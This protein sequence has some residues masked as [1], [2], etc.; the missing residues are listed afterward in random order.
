[1]RLGVLTC[2]IG[3][4]LALSSTAHAQLSGSF[5]GSGGGAVRLGY[6]SEACANG[7]RGTIRYS[8]VTKVLEI[9]NGTDWVAGAFNNTTMMRSPNDIG[10]FVLTESRWTGD[11]GGAAGADQKCLTELT[12]KTNWRGYAD[13][14]ARGLLTANKVRAFFMHV[15]I[16]LR[17]G[18]ALCHLC[19]CHSKCA[20]ERRGHFYI[21]R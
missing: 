19:V 14:Q 1:M 12:T 3:S 8:S 10:Y 9:C 21:E 13:A 2:F 6:T 11:L 7:N 18:F 17:Y 5:S 15:F 4:L 20:F 16:R